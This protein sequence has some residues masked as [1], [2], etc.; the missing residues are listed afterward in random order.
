MVSLKSVTL[1]FLQ[2]F[3]IVLNSFKSVTL[4][5]LQNFYI[6]LNIPGAITG[7]Q[8]IGYYQKGFYSFYILKLF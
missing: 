1:K 2:N 6:V 5:F 8:H 4:K 7:A 3:Y